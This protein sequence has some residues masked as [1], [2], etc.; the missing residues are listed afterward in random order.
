[1][2]RQSVVEAGARVVEESGWAGLS[3]R[4]VAT[5]LGVTPMALYR[6]VGDSEKLKAAIVEE[7]IEQL[8]PVATSNQ[9]GEGLADW[10][11]QFHDLLSRYPGLAGHLISSWFESSA[12]LGQI[13]ELLARVQAS[14]V[15]GFDAVAVVNAVFTYV[16]MRCEAERVVRSAGAVRRTLRTSAASRPLP[17]LTAL[18]EHYSTAQFDAHFEF[19]LKS[20]IAGM[21]LPAPKPRRGRSR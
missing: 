16:L 1:M 5:E 9:L 17:R 21:A 12:T 14:G 18:A 20:L 11:R 3:L 8:A 13:E 19:G 2:T 7:V 6:H 10:A 15:D 4:A